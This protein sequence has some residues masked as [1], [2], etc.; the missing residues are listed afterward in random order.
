MSLLRSMALKIPNYRYLYENYTTAT[1]MVVA[2]SRSELAPQEV[3]TSLLMSS[4]YVLQQEGRTALHYA[5][6]CR[7]EAAAAALLEGAGAARGARDASGRAPNHYRGAARTLLTLPTVPD[8]PP[9]QD[10]GNGKYQLNYKI[11]KN[12]FFYV[13]CIATNQKCNHLITLSITTRGESL[14]TTN[15]QA[16]TKFVKRITKV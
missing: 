4:L 1:T 8:M 14:T 2:D 3:C 15:I 16:L 11:F 5:S 6:L 10:K 7:D 12:Y 9:P 13:I